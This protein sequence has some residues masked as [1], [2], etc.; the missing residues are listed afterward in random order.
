[1]ALAVTGTK[2]ISWE[3]GDGCRLRRR[4]HAK[5]GLRGGPL[6]PDDAHGSCPR[7]PRSGEDFLRSFG[8][9]PLAG[10][11]G[12]A[13]T[14]PR[15]A[16]GKDIG[17]RY[18]SD[19]HMFDEDQR[20]AADTSKT[21]Y[22]QALSSQGF[23]LITHRDRRC[24]ILPFPRGL[25]PAVSGQE[26]DWSRRAGPVRSK[27]ASPGENRL[28]SEIFLAACVVLAAETLTAP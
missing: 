8:Q 18:G 16:S 22:G 23:G 20:K 28:T 24:G 10:P 12:R 27:P 6:R 21:V 19:I 26:P 5:P 9:D 11:I 13:M 7:R 15:Q 1:L 17:T 14:D 25:S 4:G 2:R 3:M